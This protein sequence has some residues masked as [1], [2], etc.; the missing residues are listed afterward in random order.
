MS[1]L[2]DIWQVKRPVMNSHVEDVKDHVEGRHD[3][4]AKRIKMRKCLGAQKAPRQAKRKCSDH[5][6][7]RASLPKSSPLLHGLPVTFCRSED[8]CL[9]SAYSVIQSALFVV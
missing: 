8:S 3:L 9:L 7:R 2:F 4:G 6:P 1:M 5:M